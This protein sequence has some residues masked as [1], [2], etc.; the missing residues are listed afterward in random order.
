M[1]P[2]SH[3]STERF[4]WSIRIWFSSCIVS[5]ICFDIRLYNDSP[6]KMLAASAVTVKYTKII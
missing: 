3:T 1:M 2:R 6:I 5:D 4:T